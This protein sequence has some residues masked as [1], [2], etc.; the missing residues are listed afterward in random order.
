MKLVSQTQVRDA[1]LTTLQQWLPY[2]LAEVE[3]SD[4]T[5]ACTVDRPREWRLVV[6]AQGDVITNQL[7]LVV[8]SVP[9]IREFRLSNPD[10]YDAVFLL[11]VNAWVP[12]RDWEDTAARC[13]TYATAIQTCLAQQQTLGGLAAWTVVSEPAV[14]DITPPSQNRSIG[15]VLVGFDV[16]VDE[17]AP[18]YADV[19]EPPADPCAAPGTYDVE[20]VQTTIAP[21]EA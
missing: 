18:R 13:S 17:A 14:M 10:C 4:G 5:P 20:T 11:A 3:R 12:G 16:R 7:P 9:A 19:D 2:Y 21:E 1:A 15:Q 6:N 8:V